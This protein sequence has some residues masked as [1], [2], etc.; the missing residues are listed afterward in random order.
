MG[1]IIYFVFG[2]IFGSFATMASHRIPLKEDLIFK[3]SHCP[4]CN[5]QL[6]VFDLFPVLSWV[7]NL[8]KCRYCNSKIHWRYP[9]IEIITATSF[10]LTFT[11]LGLTFIGL[12]VLLLIVCLIIFITI[13]AEKPKV[14]KNKN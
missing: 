8:A 9:A 5:H 13:K 2:L 1:I 7:F 3:P 12:F 11:Y 6:G 10:A 4:R 14:K